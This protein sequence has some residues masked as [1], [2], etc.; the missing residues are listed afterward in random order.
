MHSASVI[1]VNL[2][3]VQHNVR[4]LQQIIGPD[5]ALC[6]IVKADAYG[7]G[8]VRIAKTLTACGVDLMAV[9]TP[10]EATALFAAAVGGQILV[11]MPVR[12][13][14][15]ADELYRGLICGRLHLTVHDGEHLDDLIRV[16]DRF[17]V[18]IPL[19]LEIDTGMSRGG[20]SV[21]EAPTLLERIGC[22]ERLE[23]AGLFT[24]FA[25]AEVDAAFTDRQ[26]GRFDR[27]LADCAHLIPPACR[28]H[29]ANSSATLRSSRY[30][31]SMV[32]IGMAWAGYGL[33]WLEGGEVIL[34]GQNLQ[35]AVTW[36]SRII[37]TKTIESGT[38]VGYG[39]R[40]TAK[41]RSLI[42]LVPVGYAHGYPLH[43]G[44]TDDRPA[45]GMVRVLR[46]L[47]EE[48][49][50][51]FVPVVG[52]VSMDQ[53]TVDLTELAGSSSDTGGIEVGTA[54]ELITADAAAPN[55]VPTLARAAGTIPHEML[56]RLHPRIR[57]TYQ[58]AA[59]AVH[60]LS[61]RATAAAG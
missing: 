43:L 42:G 45:W 20:C 60:T 12:Q 38:P 40:W 30:H 31:K 37:Q 36:E 14:P 18:K 24:H 50:T 53:I 23:L 27:V 1:D 15:R 21:A 25:K 61:A 47:P 29:A 34:E 56:C 28:I 33:E 49:A 41:R 57:R 32:R 16:A 26:V 19:H 46:K 55:H 39:S 44:A 8:A 54:V 10:Q 52:A 5:C 2:S 3:A 7:L 11:L 6:P 58:F 59:A 51:G 48:T 13:I 17:G 9:Y 22:H 4:L 35:P